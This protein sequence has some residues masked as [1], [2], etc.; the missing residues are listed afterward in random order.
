MTQSLNEN[1]LVYLLK[2]SDGTLYCGATNNLEKRIKA[3]NNK[4]GAKY[5]KT[6]TPVEL[7][8][9]SE[10]M[11]KSNALKLEYKIKQM[12]REDKLKLCQT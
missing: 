12:S 3:H 5:T 8:W 11:S 9:K 1:W 4:K 10:L 2:C 7:F 6:R